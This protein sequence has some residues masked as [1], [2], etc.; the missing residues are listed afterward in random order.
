MNN[1]PKDV[2]I[3]IYRYLHRERL[4]KIHKN[5]YNN[6]LCRNL[7]RNHDINST[8]TIVHCKICKIWDVV[9]YSILNKWRSCNLCFMRGA[10]KLV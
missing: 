4:I 3:I 1:L 10:Y 9:H 5:I 6:N 8:Y 7:C 2:A